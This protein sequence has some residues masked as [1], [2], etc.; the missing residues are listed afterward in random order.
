MDRV[1]TSIEV[2]Q[3][4]LGTNHLDARWTPGTD[5]I[6]VQLEEGATTAT[7]FEYDQARELAVRAQRP[8]S[9]AEPVPGAG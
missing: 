7:Q 3:N 4:L 1:G 9:H 8:G 5:H 6:E 2:I